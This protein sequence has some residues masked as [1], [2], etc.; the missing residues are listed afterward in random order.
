MACT[1]ADVDA[2]D[3][4]KALSYA[5]PAAREAL[6]VGDCTC[7]ACTARVDGLAALLV[8]AFKAGREVENHWWNYESQ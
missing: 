2:A 7:P 3:Q 5:V 6:K 1:M 4:A 8:V